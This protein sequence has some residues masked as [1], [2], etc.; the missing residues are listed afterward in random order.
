MLA[1]NEVAAGA[2]LDTRRTG[3]HRSAVCLGLAAAAVV[4]EHQ[5]IQRGAATIETSL[6]SGYKPNIDSIN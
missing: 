2:V 3:V 4:P 5:R 6:A 1:D